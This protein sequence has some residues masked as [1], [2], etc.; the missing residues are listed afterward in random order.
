[1]RRLLVGR[2]HV[3]ALMSTTPRLL[4]QDDRRGNGFRDRDDGRGSGGRDRNDDRSFRDRDSG[5]DGGFRDEGR[6]FG[7]RDRN[8]DRDDFRNRDSRGGGRDEGRGGG[9]DEG[10]GRESGGFRGRDEGRGGFQE[11]DGGRGGGRDEGRG[12]FRDENRGRE[13]GGFRGR[14]DGGRGAGRDEGRGGGFRDE[15]RGRESGGYR[16]R[17]DDRSGFQDRARESV[18]FRGRDEGRGGF[19]ERDGGRGGGRDEG[20]GGGFRDESRGRES[21]DFRG[22]DEGR[23]SRGVRDRSRSESGQNRDELNRD[24]GRSGARDDYRSQ[25]DDRIRE[26]RFGDRRGDRSGT[27]ARGTTDSKPRDSN[28]EIRIA[29]RSIASTMASPQP[30]KTEERVTR[31]AQELHQL[32]RQFKAAKLR[33]ERNDLIK[34]SKRVVYSLNL[35]PSTQDEKSVALLLNGAAFFGIIYSAPAL[36]QAVTWMS[37]NVSALES[38]HLAMFAHAVVALKVPS[39]AAI[40]TNVI[41][42]VASEFVSAGKLTPVELIMVLQAIART[43]VSGQEKLVNDILARLTESAAKLKTSELSTLCAVFD[44]TFLSGKEK[45]VK[46]ILTEGLKVVDQSMDSVHSNDILLLAEHLAPLASQAGVTTIFWGKFLSRAIAVAGFFGDR[47]LPHAFRGLREMQKLAEIQNEPAVSA[48]MIDYRQALEKRLDVCK[49]AFNLEGF[50]ELLESLLHC[51]SSNN[52]QN[53]LS[54]V[55]GGVVQSCKFQSNDI[56]DFT[57][58]VKA[59]SRFGMPFDALVE[60]CVEFALGKGRRAPRSGEEDSVT[61]EPAAALPK[62]LEESIR[63]RLENKQARNIF[64]LVQIRLFAEIAYDNR[65]LPSSLSEELPKLILQRLHLA[66]PES[67]LSVARLL[68][69]ADGQNPC[70]N[71]VNSSDILQAIA[72]RAKN[73]RDFF[74]MVTTPGFLESF[75]ALDV[76]GAIVEEAKKHLSQ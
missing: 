30:P 51:Q 14:D 38:Q 46:S 26:Q 76:S 31:V 16:G 58:C 15:N 50:T 22:R 19:Q 41:L 54:Q 2:L 44:S 66:H 53:Y 42:P 62:E 24:G 23:D 7:G 43:N 8:D 59:I 13:S 39:A 63:M 18:G 3:G 56:T 33:R 10:R 48:R 25:D 17:D 32:K 20:R 70:A 4:W 74:K 69:S 71:S 49:N 68:Y 73:E 61:G 55:A 9:R 72:K 29:Q 27:D 57:R 1:M 28:Q 60:T 6:G 65:T 36:Q 40:L 34:Q 37:E 35:D 45:S 67:L 11:R 47:Q 52:L 64:E 75:A 12:G 21:S 5:R